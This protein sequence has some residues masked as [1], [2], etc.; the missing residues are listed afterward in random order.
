MLWH[1]VRSRIISPSEACCTNQKST[2]KN[3][4]IY[5]VLDGDG[6]RPESVTGDGKPYISLHRYICMEIGVYV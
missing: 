2:T 5:I 4:K 1:Y 6:T 3:Q